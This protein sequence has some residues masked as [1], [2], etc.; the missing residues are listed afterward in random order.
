MWRSETHRK[1]PARRICT[2]ARRPPERPE[3]EASSCL[4]QIEK[5]SSTYDSYISADSCAALRW[6]APP[7]AAPVHLAFE[8]AQQAASLEGRRVG[9]IV[10]LLQ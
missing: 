6:V 5:R 10:V 9:L 8:V 2:V 3:D 4:E 7:E 1:A